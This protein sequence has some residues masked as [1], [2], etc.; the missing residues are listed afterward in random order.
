MAAGAPDWI[1]EALDG[2]GYL[3][4]AALMLVCP[5]LPS[6]LVL[7]SAGFY[8][9]RSGL[10]LPAAIAAASVGALGHAL[11]VYWLARGGRRLGGTRAPRGSE[12]RRRRLAEL[13]VWFASNAE[14]AVFLGRVASGVRWLVGIPAGLTRMPLRRYVP[15]TAAGC[16]VWNTALMYAGATAEADGTGGLAKA[17]SLVAVTVFGA[18]LLARRLLRRGVAQAKPLR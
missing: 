2:I 17:I 12:R 9:A 7:P 6:E 8:T 13:E 18:T 4:I 10:P 15:L 16:T 1:L 11:A 14:R 3:G 5:P